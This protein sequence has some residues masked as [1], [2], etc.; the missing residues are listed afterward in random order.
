MLDE[1]VAVFV[2]DLVAMTMSL[3]YLRHAVDHRCLGAYSEPARIR[4]ES[5]RTA[6]IRYV[7]LVFH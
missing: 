5:H 3:A 2:V 6:D 7:L 1:L 4:A